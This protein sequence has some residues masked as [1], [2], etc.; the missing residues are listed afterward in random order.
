M[1]ALDGE[2]IPGI[3]VS[4]HPGRR[5]RRNPASPAASSATTFVRRAECPLWVKSR[6]FT[7]PS[8]MSAFGG[9]ADVNHC[10]GECP[11]IAISGHSATS[12]RS[13][14]SSKI[15]CMENPL[16]NAFLGPSQ[17]ATHRRSVGLY[18]KQF[19]SVPRRT[20]LSI[21]IRPRRFAPTGA[22]YRTTFDP[23]HPATS[24]N[25]PL[26]AHAF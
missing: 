4:D 1:P 17:A 15:G 11:L 16:E 9:K 24:P 20:T 21:G 18:G 8:R 12:V 25:C 13:P 26:I 5:G 6:R 19:I 22:E 3:R 14:K 23:Q 2:T 7:A 10:V